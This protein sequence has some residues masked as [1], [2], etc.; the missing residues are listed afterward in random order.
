MPRQFRRS[1]PVPVGANTGFPLRT[2]T[3]SFVHFRE[4]KFPVAN[5][6]SAVCSQCEPCPCTCD[7]C[8][9]ATVPLRPDAF[10]AKVPWA[11][12]PMP[13]RPRK[14][15]IRAKTLPRRQLEGPVGPNCRKCVRKDDD[16]S[17]PDI[18]WYFTKFLIDRKGRVVA[19]F[20]P[21]VTPEELDAEINALL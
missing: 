9:P 3:A 8:S 21:V 11:S 4:L 13:T 2:I 6:K 19:R 5:K 7:T 15:S 10:A 16:A 1:P 18:K 12:F 20:E 17:N 14:G